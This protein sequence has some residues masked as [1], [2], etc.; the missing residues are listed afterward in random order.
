M[1]AS[2][3]KATGGEYLASQGKYTKTTIHTH[4]LSGG[5]KNLCMFLES[6]PTRGEYA[7]GL[8][9]KIQTPISENVRQM[10]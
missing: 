4:S 8:K 1:I 7:K 2:F 10:C 3:N 5:K 9:G 6:A